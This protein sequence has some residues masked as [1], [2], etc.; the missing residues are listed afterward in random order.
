MP[1]AHSLHMLVELSFFPW[2]PP[3][4]T[5]TLFYLFGARVFSPTF[6][7]QRCWCWCWCWRRCCCYH[8]LWF[9]AVPFFIPCFHF[10]AAPFCTNTHTH[11]TDC[12]HRSCVICFLFSVFFILSFN[13]PPFKSAYFYASF[14]YF[15]WL[16]GFF[17]AVSKQNVEP[18]GNTARQHPERLPHWRMCKCVCVGAA[19]ACVHFHKSLLNGLLHC[20]MTAMSGL[21]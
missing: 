13:A 21:G 18:V 5:F 3:E 4:I 2:I 1:F 11:T 19:S 12:F 17:Y 8:Y 10:I 20:N 15:V 7:I 14:L 9:F 6:F 16:T